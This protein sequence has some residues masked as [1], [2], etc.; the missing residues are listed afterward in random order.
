MKKAGVSVEM[1]IY[2]TGGHGFGV[3]KVDHPCA[4][5]TDACLAWLRSQGILKK[6]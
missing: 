6:Q 4:A 1:H 2:A 3:R 5:W